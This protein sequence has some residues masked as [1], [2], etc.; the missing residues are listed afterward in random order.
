[1]PAE[2]RLLCT[3]RALSLLGNYLQV[4]ALPLWVL[5][6]TG[7]PVA[8]GLAFAVEILPIVLLAPWAGHFVDRFDRRTVLVTAE[9]ASAAAVGLLL[10][11]V[12]RESLP[13][14]YAALLLVRV[15]DVAATPSV[16][17]ILASRTPQDQL[18]RIVGGFEAL[19]G[20]VM[21]VGPVAGT[22]AMGAFGI[23]ALLVANL[24]SFAVSSLL[25]SRLP[26]VPG[27]AD[28]GPVG[29]GLRAAVRLVLGDPRLRPVALAELAYFLCSGGITTLS[30]L[31][32]APG[33]GPDLTGLYT[34]GVGLGWLLCSLLVVRPHRLRPATMLVAGLIGCVPVGLL[35]W[36]V[37]GLNPVACFAGGVV[38]GSVNVLVVTAITVLFTARVP[39]AAV[40]RV[41]AGRRAALN[42]ALLL[43]HL[44]LPAIAQRVGAGATAL[45]ACSVTAAV[46]LALLLPLTAA[47]EP[48]GAAS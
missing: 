47:R 28:L 3:A 38:A 20:A 40:G 14:V 25:N 27:S 48:A 42:L 7:S 36:R 2:I 12:T 43:S 46:C 5:T 31:I 35:L 6:V 15:F 13:L 23:E 37:V 18:T 30:L 8:T 22:L 34:G 11:A 17:A 32:A 26:R 16:S 10:V 33:V 9:A 24:L 4:T 39:A 41:F 29:A 45:V 44:A 21:T 19:V 1:M